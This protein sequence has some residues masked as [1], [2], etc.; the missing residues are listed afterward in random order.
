LPN[1]S[2]IGKPY[3]NRE[4]GIVVDNADTGRGLRPNPDVL[5]KRLDEAA[6]LVDIATNRIFELNET[7][8]R[9]W[10]LVCQGFDADQIAHQLV[11]EFD[12]Q[13]ERAAYE[14]NE[15]IVRLRAEGLLAS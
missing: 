12:V 9:A 8:T 14:L 15:L 2:G 11:D 3:Q 4:R 7:G 5:S 1:S 13:P 6:V 10:E